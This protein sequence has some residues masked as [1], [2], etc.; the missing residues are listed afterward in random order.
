MYKK[1]YIQDVLP[2]LI[3]AFHILRTL[4]VETL[5]W[6]LCLEGLVVMFVLDVLEN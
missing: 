3:L 6:R 5:G 4:S 1:E 2:Y